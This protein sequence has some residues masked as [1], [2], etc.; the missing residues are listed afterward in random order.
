[1]LTA[2]KV[3]RAKRP[4]RYSC[5]LIRGLYLQVTAS[6]TKS[7]VLRYQLRG[8]E[9][10]MGLGSASDFSLKEVRERAR[11]ARQ[12]LADR[13]DPLIGKQAAEEA[14][15]LAEARKLTFA[16]AAQQYF[17]QHEA[18]WRSAKH[19]EQFLSSL[20]AFAF[21][22]LGNMDVASID[23]RD[24]LRALEP[25]WTSKSVTADRTRNRIEQVMDWC[26]VRG[27][28]PPGTNPARWKGHLDQVLPLPRQLAPIVHHK[29]MHYRDVPDFMAALRAQATVAA[30]A[31]QFLVLTAARSNEVLGARWSE[32]DFT[33]KV[34]T[35]PASRMKGGREHRVP[36]SGAV[37]GLLEKLPREDGN[38]HVFMGRQPG[39]ALSQWAMPW[40]MEHMGQRGQTTIHGFRAGFSTRA[41]EQT[42][43]ASHTI[44][45]S[46]AH[47]VGTEV[48]R[49][50]RRSDLVSKR[51]QLMEQWA[52]FCLSP[53]S[54]VGKAGGEVVS[55]RGGR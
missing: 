32:I 41:H 7:W 46:L 28:R 51:A 35:V 29:A 13:I 40:I 33:D 10:W 48:E 43:H 50:Y 5:G 53:P 31:L 1:M 23:T 18:K 55:L 17:N 3:E 44:E 19:R 37:L 20:A 16:E 24:V 34:W 2:R 12:L 45:I 27:H 49:A 11:Q 47:N 4:G 39:A 42:A 54:K 21:P 22:V 6:G 30:Q 15:R 38:P 14:A 26:V 25:V 8:R 36:L 52:R 9:R